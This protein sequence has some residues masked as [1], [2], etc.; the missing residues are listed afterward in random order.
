MGAGR[1]SLCTLVYICTFSIGLEFEPQG[2]GTLV[3]AGCVPAVL[4][5]DQRVLTALVYVY[6]EHVLVPPVSRLTDH[7]TVVRPLGV[8]T[9]L[10]RPTPPIIPATLVQILTGPSVTTQDVPW[11]TGAGKPPWGVVTVVGAG[12]DWPALIIIKTELSTAVQVKAGGALVTG[13]TWGDAGEQSK[14]YLV[15]CRTDR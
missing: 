11:G 8:Q 9:L 6:T 12:I 13:S 7:G 15:P 4:S 2:T 14:L 10:V 3:G 5:T 1:H